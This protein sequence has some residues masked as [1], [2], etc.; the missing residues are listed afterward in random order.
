MTVGLGKFSLLLLLFSLLVTGVVAFSALSRRSWLATTSGAALIAGTTIRIPN[1]NDNAAAFAA[2]PPLE[3]VYFGVG[4]FW[5]IQHEFIQA[6]RDLLGRGDAQ[7]TSLAGYAGGKSVKRADGTGLPLVCYH[8]L[9]GVADYGALGHG[10]V[11]G[12]K[13]P[14]DT[15][16]TFGKVYFSLFNP[17]TKGT[18]CSAMI[19]GWVFCWQPNR[20]LFLTFHHHPPLQSVSI[21][22][23]AVQNTAVSLGYRVARIMHRTVPSNRPRIWPVSRWQSVRAMIPTRSAKN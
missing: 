2:T 5:H 3:D 21:R 18:D 7:L 23:I 11:V 10:E 20:S 1:D 19:H 4:C 12:M 6:E 17:K 16:E 22:T 14:S 9:M 13:L 15:I 8:N